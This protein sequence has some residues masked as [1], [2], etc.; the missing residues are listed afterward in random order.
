M[1]ILTVLL[2]VAPA[3]AAAPV[4]A[5]PAV[6]VAAP[7]APAVFRLGPHT[8]KLGFQAF[9]RLTDPHGHFKTW[10]GEVRVPGGDLSKATMTV[11]VVIATINTDIIKRDKH[12]QTP[13]FFNVPKWPKAV[14]RSSSIKALGSGR[15]QVRGTLTMMGAKKSVSFPAKISLAGGKLKVKAAFDIDRTAWGM[16]GYLSSFSI[17]PI[18]KKV[19]IYFDLAAE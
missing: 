4:P 10:R 14:F 11:T 17:N 5:S 15:F 12:L 16:T 9:S 6:A 2:L 1:P 13:D 18:R 3:P 8:G 7:A 19:H